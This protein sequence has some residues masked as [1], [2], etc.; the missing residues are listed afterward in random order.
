[1]YAALIVLI[2]MNFVSTKIDN[3][4]VVDIVVKTFWRMDHVPCTHLRKSLVSNDD[5][6]QILFMI[7]Y[8][9]WAQVQNKNFI[10]KRKLN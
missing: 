10:I 9:L 5:C 8:E 3:Y 4:I 6:N 2:C 7:H 1:M